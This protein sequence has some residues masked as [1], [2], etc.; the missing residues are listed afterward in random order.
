MPP[1]KQAVVSLQTGGHVGGDSGQS[2]ILEQSLPQ[3][4]G[5]QKSLYLNSNVALSLLAVTFGWL[6]NV[7]MKL[8]EAIIVV[9]ASES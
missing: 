1:L 6:R 3:D 4:P 5:V 8:F 2:L 7:G 9:F